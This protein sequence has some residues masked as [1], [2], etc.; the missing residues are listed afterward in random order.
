MDSCRPVERVAG[1]YAFDQGRFVDGSH[2]YVHIGIPTGLAYR[3]WIRLLFA[4]EDEAVLGG[5]VA[6]AAAAEIGVLYDPGVIGGGATLAGLPL[7]ADRATILR[8]VVEGSAVASARVTRALEA[9]ARA[10]AERIVVAGHAGRNPLWRELRSGLTGRTIELV[11]EPEAAALGAAL[12]AQRAVT[13]AADVDAVTRTTWS[14]TPLDLARGALLE[15]RYSRN[16]GA[17]VVGG[18]QP[19]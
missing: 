14:P 3:Q 16:A 8:A 13:G 2:W 6:S 1:G 18:G 17:V 5:E 11:D 4:D 12:M 9:A 7:T 19:A 15:E 10:H